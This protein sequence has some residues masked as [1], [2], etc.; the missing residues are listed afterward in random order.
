VFTDSRP[1]KRRKLARVAT[2]ASLLLTPCT[3]EQI[4]HDNAWAADNADDGK[5]PPASA[6][7]PGDCRG[8]D[9]GFLPV[10]R[11]WEAQ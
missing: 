9:P 10:P 1:I 3:A 5:A 7:E 11:T 2:T 6:D 8:R 4:A